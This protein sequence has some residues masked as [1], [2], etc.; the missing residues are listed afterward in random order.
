MDKKKKKKV[1][2]TVIQGIV[3]AVLIGIL[4]WFVK[5]IMESNYEDFSI[6]DSSGRQMKIFKDEEAK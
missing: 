4:V 5:G 1:L 2:M 3:V 6:R